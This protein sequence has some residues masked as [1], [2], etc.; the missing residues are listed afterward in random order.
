M[1]DTLLKRNR[2]KCGYAS[3]SDVESGVRFFW[4]PQ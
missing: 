4:L 1:Q 3:V 2:G